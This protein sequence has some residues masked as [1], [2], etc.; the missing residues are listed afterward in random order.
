MAQTINLAQD[1][2]RF[3]KVITRG[4]EIGLGKGK[5]YEKAGLPQAQEL[6]GY[7]SYIH[8][9]MAVLDTH[10][11][12][13]DLFAFPAFRKVVPDAPYDQL[14]ADH[15][16]IERLMLGMPQAITEL[17][18]S[19]AG[20]GLN[21]IVGSLGKISDI[22]YPHIQLEE[23]YFSEAQLNATLTQ[24][25]QKGIFNASSKNSQEHANPASWVIPFVVF[26]LEQ[27]E[28]VKMVANFPPTVMEEL[29]P[30]VWKDQWLP[31]KPFLLE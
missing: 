28:R 29:V 21:A 23:E 22:W 20:Q 27:D 6:T 25:E 15:R 2:F 8:S 31:M 5:E 26:N 17:A 19:S 4:L 11:S 30:K 14:A 7:A 24:E 3:H 10:H 16:A 13:E 18:G 1:F 9:C 12:S